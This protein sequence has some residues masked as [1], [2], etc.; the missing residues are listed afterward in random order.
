MSAQDRTEEVL[1][2]FHILFSKAEPIPGSAR[3]V[4]VD[5]IEA[6]ALLQELNECMYDML[7][8]HAL[9]KS[10]R[11]RASREMQKQGDE[12][13]FSATRQA[14]DIYAAS[15]MYTDN[16][17]RRIQ[18]IISETTDSL[19]Q[20]HTSTVQQLKEEQAGI[21][22]NRTDLRS[23]LEGLIDTQTYIRLIEEDRRRQAKAEA[24]GETEPEDQSLYA[25]IQAEVQIN[26]DYFI[27]HGLAFEDDDLPEDDE[28]ADGLSGEDLDA[29]YFQWQQES[30]PDGAKP[31]KKGFSLFGK[32]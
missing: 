24:A 21:K 9:S 11:E 32:K 31:E 8:E 19:N 7:E 5:K 2:K 3:D 6:M 4:V 28:L 25:G 17:L 29:E 23:Q 16:A 26:K 12:I 18:T 10:G 30:D 27:Q 22:H 20:L 14:E 13:I 1:R 15:I